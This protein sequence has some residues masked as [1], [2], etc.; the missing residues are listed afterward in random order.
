MAKKHYRQLHKSDNKMLKEKKIAINFLKV[1]KMVSIMPKCQFLFL[2][3]F[4]CTAYGFHKQQCL[5]CHHFEQEEHCTQECS[6][7]HYV[8][9]KFSHFKNLLLA[10]NQSNLLTLFH[11]GR[12]GHWYNDSNTIKA[13]QAENFISFIA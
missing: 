7:N 3:F 6:A 8:V 12:G 11:V 10:W 13:F 9:S 1:A 5:E 4:R 2:L